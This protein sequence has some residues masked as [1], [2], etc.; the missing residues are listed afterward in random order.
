MTHLQRLLSIGLISLFM[1]QSPFPEAQAESVKCAPALVDSLLSLRRASLNTTCDIARFLTEYRS[2][3]NT[4]QF[5]TRQ[6]YRL[7]MMRRHQ[8]TFIFKTGRADL[9]QAQWEESKDKLSLMVK[10]SSSHKAILVIGSGESKITHSRSLAARRIK[11]VI[12]QMIESGLTAE[13]NHLF[14]TLIGTDGDKLSYSMME[15]LG[16]ITQSAERLLKEMGWARRGVHVNQSVMLLEFPCVPEMCEAAKAKWGK[17]RV[18]DESQMNELY[19]REC[20]PLI[21]GQL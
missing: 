2:K 19:L 9:D 15:R 18:C 8:V 16:M 10:D 13:C 21:C 5:N 11:S 17:E 14:F 4:G 6:L 12:D 7:L 3:S 20:V 1:L